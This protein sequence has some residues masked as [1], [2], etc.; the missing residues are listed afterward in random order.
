MNADGT[1]ARKLDD[2]YGWLGPIWSPDGKGLVVGD[3]A[4]KPP[5]FYLLDPAG[6]SP[7][8]EL[9]LPAVAPPNQLSNLIEIPAWQRV[10][11]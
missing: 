8:V 4:F 6:K 2:R 5:K 3:D 9:K 1:G 7:R 10:G 11:Q